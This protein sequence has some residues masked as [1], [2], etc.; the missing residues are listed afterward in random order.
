MEQC[1][2]YFLK[3]GEI[4]VSSDLTIIHTVLGSC[5]SVC[6]YDTRNDIGGMNHFIYHHA[7][8]NARSCRYGDVAVPHLIKL[9]IKMG[10]DPKNFIAHIVGGSQNLIPGSFIGDENI[11]IAKEIL[12]KYG[13]PIGVIDIGGKAFRKL[14]FNNLSGEIEIKRGEAG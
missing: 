4:F 1:G 5:V 2:Y 14:K 10:G 7:M 6:I 12:Q 9:L 11:K 8:I 13:I 3:P